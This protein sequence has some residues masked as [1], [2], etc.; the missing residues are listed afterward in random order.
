MTGFSVKFDYCVS[1]CRGLCKARDKL[2]ESVVMARLS[3]DSQC[4]GCPLLKWQAVSHEMTQPKICAHCLA[5]HRASS[6][7]GKALQSGEIK[8]VG[9]G[10][11]SLTN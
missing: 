7:N 9:L 1:D 11:T 10:P 6:D 4:H 3:F 8:A 5:G 2:D